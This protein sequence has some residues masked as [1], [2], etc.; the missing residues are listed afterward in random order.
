MMIR[1]ETEAS[2]TKAV[3]D[4][5]HVFKW[6]CAH[7]RPARTAQGWRTPVQGD[8][9]GFPDLVLVRRRTIIVA[10]LKVGKNRPTLDQ[11]KWLDVF[12]EAGVRTY[13]WRPE[14]WNEIESIL[15]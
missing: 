3:I 12:R 4:L 9:A 2:F 14:M 11:Q 13:L 6:R 5:A 7:F 15:R 8:G 10:E 1:T